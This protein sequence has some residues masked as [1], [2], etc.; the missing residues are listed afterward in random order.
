MNT[1]HVKSDLYVGNLDLILWPA[2]IE[3]TYIESDLDMYFQLFIHHIDPI[4][5]DSNAM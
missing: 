4:L 2:R 3:S 1:N 5:D